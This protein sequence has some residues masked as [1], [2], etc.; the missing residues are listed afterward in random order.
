MVSFNKFWRILATGFCFSIFGLGGVLFGL[1]IF[2]VLG[3]FYSDSKVRQTKV[4]SLI[5]CLFHFFIRLM[6]FV[7]I[8][9]LKIQGLKELSESE[10]LIVI[11]NHPSLIDVVVLIAYIKNADCI[12]K[13]HLLKNPFMRWVILNAGYIS[14]SDPEALLQ[15]C[16]KSLDAGSNLII[17]PEGT[18]NKTNRT[19]TSFKEGSRIIALKNRLPILPLYIQSDADKVL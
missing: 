17:F 2:P 1:F 19:L 9:R 10:G 4:R 6:V 18:R 12:V 7:G 8:M 5:K 11:A 14:N 16:R 3:V 13:S 15:Q